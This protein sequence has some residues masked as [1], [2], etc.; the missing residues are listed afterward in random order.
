MPTNITI[1][2]GNSNIRL[3]KYIIK[4]I[5]NI[6]IQLI[7][8]NLSQ[9][10]IR[11]NNKQVNPN[12][13]LALNDI[14]SFAFPVKTKNDVPMIQDQKVKKDVSVDVVFEDDNILIANKPIALA[15]HSD[16]NNEDSM[17]LR[18]Q[19][20]CLQDTDFMKKN[21]HFLTQLCNRLDINTSG[22]MIFAK[23][24][25]AH[26]E[27]NKII[28]SRNIHKYYLCKVF[29]IFEEKHDILTDYLTI[30]E[31]SYGVDISKRKIDDRWVKIQTEY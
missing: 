6:S 11:V 30:N 8:K 22:L 25:P 21:N 29:G 13:K 19:K 3:D 4:N 20:Y 17:L 24:K 5:K 18:V 9:G 10:L 12:Y 31:D 14:V 1:D 2:S 16:N 7:M 15:S 26:T 28:A 23:N 27:M